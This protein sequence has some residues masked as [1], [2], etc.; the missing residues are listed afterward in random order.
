MVIIVHFALKLHFAVKVHK[1]T[2]KKNL[3]AIVLIKVLNHDID[4]NF[5]FLVEL[6]LS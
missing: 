3:H 5:L 1:P 6:E 2:V 4:V